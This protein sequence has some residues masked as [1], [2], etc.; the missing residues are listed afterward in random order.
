MVL[1]R[2]LFD[3]PKNF[4][5]AAHAGARGAIEAGSMDATSFLEVFF[6][7]LGGWGLRGYFWSLGEG[8]SRE[9]LVFPVRIITGT[10]F[11][12]CA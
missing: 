8:I 7:T 3:F 4:N 10:M 6:E 9:C 2:G 12:P 1:L 11:I 5:V